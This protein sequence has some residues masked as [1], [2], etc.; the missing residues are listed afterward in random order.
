MPSLAI[1]WLGDYTTKWIVRNSRH[2]VAENLAASAWI[3]TKIVESQ[4]PNSH[5]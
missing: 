3:W 1:R 4:F 2:G 5:A